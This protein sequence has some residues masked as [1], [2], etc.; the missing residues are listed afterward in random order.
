MSSVYKR[1]WS[2]F[3]QVNFILDYFFIDWN[4]T[5]KT[6]EQNI[7]YSTE[8]LLNKINEL[9]DN[10]AFFKKNQQVKIENSS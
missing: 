6:E 9:L 7:D 4:E 1:D 5:L 10:F 8:I 3:D 2:N